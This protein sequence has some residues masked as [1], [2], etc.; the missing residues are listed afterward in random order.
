MTRQRKTGRREFLRSLAAG[1]V[2]TKLLGGCASET[3]QP[4]EIIRP[5]EIRAERA[6]CQENQQPIA[7]QDYLGRLEDL[8]KQGDYEAAKQLCDNSMNVIVPVKRS[9]LKELASA[10]NH[11]VEIG[12]LLFADSQGRIIR[13]ERTPIEPDGYRKSSVYRDDKKA[14]DLI[15]AIEKEGCA[16]VGTYHNHCRTK[17]EIERVVSDW[18]GPNF[19]D[20]V[21]SPDDLEIFRKIDELY[22]EATGYDGTI[23]KNE[24][25]LMIGGLDRNRDYR[26]RIRAFTGGNSFDLKSYEGYNQFVEKY[27]KTKRPHIGSKLCLELTLQPFD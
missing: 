20:N 10:F 5:V 12:Y 2:G 18:G 16:F 14:E 26:F 9:V 11:K 19:E 17:E 23:Q 1:L 27:N 21:P 24:K 15:R 8:L 13:A 25:F 6:S 3:N 22:N 7:Y 4:V